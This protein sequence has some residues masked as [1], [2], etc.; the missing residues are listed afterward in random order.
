MVRDAVEK[1]VSIALGCVDEPESI[2]STLPGQAPEFVRE[3]AGYGVPIILE[4]REDGSLL[5]LLQGKGRAKPKKI[6]CRD[7]RNEPFHGNN[8]FPV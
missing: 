6:R 1:N 7:E 2:H 3:I 5:I 4:E 8:P